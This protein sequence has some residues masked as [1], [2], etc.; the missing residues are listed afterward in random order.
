MRSEY[1]KWCKANSQTPNVV[2]LSPG[3][4]AYWLG[5]PSAQNVVLYFNGM[6]S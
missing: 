6:I 5:S 2:T 4:E 3:V 1:E